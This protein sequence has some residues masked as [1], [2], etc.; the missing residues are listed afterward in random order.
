MTA[1]VRSTTGTQLADR[2]V[3]CTE[4]TALSFES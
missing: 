3:Q 4:S 2:T 1:I